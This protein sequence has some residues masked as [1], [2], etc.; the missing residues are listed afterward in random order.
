VDAKHIVLAT[1]TGLLR[2]GK[3]KADVVK[4]AIQDLGINPEKP[5][6]VVS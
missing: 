2:E 3:V 5:D 1:L 6:P 4:K